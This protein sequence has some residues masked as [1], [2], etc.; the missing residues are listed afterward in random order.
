[1]PVKLCC[2]MNLTRFYKELEANGVAR[3]KNYKLF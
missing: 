2:I 3:E 1:M